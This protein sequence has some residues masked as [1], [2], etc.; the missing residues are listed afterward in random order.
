ME[1]IDP[2]AITGQDWVV[3]PSLVSFLWLLLIFNVGF[4]GSML[5]AH[6][7]IP[8]LIETTHLPAEMSKARPVLTVIGLLSLSASVFMVLS[9]LGVL[10][11]I[12]DV[13]PKLLI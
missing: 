11:I 13:Y 10:P 9:W 6:I 3:L 12:Y 4:A 5:L 2:R 8:S 7:A 1:P